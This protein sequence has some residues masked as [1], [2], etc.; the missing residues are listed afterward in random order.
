MEEE[1]EE[2][3]DLLLKQ[4]FDK[5][6][7]EFVP[8]LTGVI[9]SRRYTPGSPLFIT[10]DLTLMRLIN[11]SHSEFT[12]REFFQSNTILQKVYELH[13]LLFDRDILPLN[14]AA[15]LVLGDPQKAFYVSSSS[16]FCTLC[17]KTKRNKTKS[18][19]NTNGH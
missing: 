1:V 14:G 15:L 19:N 7:K 5:L 11:L 10:L 9:I 16:L 3:D 4:Q 12:K 6:V 17:E 8:Q 2:E 18:K 13:M